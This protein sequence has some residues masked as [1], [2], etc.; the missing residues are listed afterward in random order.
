MVGLR[1]REQVGN[2]MLLLCAVSMMKVQALNKFIVSTT[3]ALAS[4]HGDDLLFQQ[5][6]GLIITMIA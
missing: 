5:A 6:P 3:H 2:I 1:H 4:E